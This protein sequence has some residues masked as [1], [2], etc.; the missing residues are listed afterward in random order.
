MLDTVLLNWGRLENTAVETCPYL[1]DSRSIREQVLKQSE[2]AQQ[3]YLL[4]LDFF[5]SE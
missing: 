3:P 5:S 1:T 2:L 4:S